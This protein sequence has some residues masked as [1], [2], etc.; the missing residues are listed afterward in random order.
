MLGDEI[1]HLRRIVLKPKDR[2]LT[3]FT[4]NFTNSAAVA[5]AVSELGQL[6]ELGNKHF[7]GAKAGLELR[8]KSLASYG[9]LQ[10]PKIKIFQL[11]RQRLITV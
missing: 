1:D 4:D 10:F 3:V 2:R 6:T 9:V 11:T 7:L 8:P 5:Y